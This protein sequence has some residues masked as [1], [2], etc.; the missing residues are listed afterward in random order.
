VVV[1]GVG[2]VVEVDASVVLV[3]EL[4]VVVVVA[5]PTGPI[6]NAPAASSDPEATAKAAHRPRR[7]PNRTC[8]PS[9][10]E[11]PIWLFIRIDRSAAPCPTLEERRRFLPYPP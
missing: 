5:A 3:V 4:D 7:E 6:A 10:I 8:R 11:T 1:T 2:V 9:F